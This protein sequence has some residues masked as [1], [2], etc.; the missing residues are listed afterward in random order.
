MSV[1]TNV[2]P[3]LKGGSARTAGLLPPGG[4]T[5]F[6][7]CRVGSYRCG[8]LLD[9]VEETMRPLPCEPLAGA[10]GIVSGVAVIRGDVVPVVDAG[11]LLGT[12]G[13]SEGRFVTIRVEGRRAAIKVDAVIGVRDVAN[14]SLV[15]L[16]P[17]LDGAGGEVVAALGAQG[18][19]LL[20]VLRE[21]RLVPDSVW[22]LLED[23][24]PA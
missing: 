19:E 7:V 9:D 12:G 8:I 20:V 3:A 6:L 18:S 1:E 13:S 21:A 14:D 5:S 2:V 15:G 22:A 23:H 10:I 16:P 11:V 17:L 4:A 24:Q